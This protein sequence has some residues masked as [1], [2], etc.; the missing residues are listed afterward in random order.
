MTKRK[1]HGHSIGGRKKTIASVVVH[2]S[3]LSLFI[4]YLQAS[5]RLELGH[6][7]KT[8]AMSSNGEKEEEKRVSLS[9]PKEGSTRG[10]EVGSREE[11]EGE[12]EE[13]TVFFLFLFSSEKQNELEGKGKQG[14]AECYKSRTLKGK[15]SNED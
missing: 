9:S 8:T 14:R 13:T 1:G 3:S 2:R 5:H 12:S 15:G 6:G 11:S 10:E 4:L 7:C